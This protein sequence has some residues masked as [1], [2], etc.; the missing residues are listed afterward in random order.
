MGII[1]LGGE[2]FVSRYPAVDSVT[3]GCSISPF[4]AHLS[5]D[6]GIARILDSGGD[7]AQTLIGTPFYMSPEILSSKP[8]GTKSDVWSLGCCLYEMVSLKHA[9]DAKEMGSLVYKVLKG[10]VPPIPKAYSENIRSLIKHLLSTNPED[11][12]SIADCLQ[13][14]FIRSHIL[15]L[16]DKNSALL[17]GYFFF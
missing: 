8:Y 16:L 7:L 3:V 1:K 2:F 12:P 4:P 17:H 14:P 5:T 15:A 6:L 13:K 9:F 10:E 11:R